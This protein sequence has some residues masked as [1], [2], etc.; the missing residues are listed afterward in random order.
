MSFF[1]NLFSRAIRVTIP[2]VILLTASATVLADGHPLLDRFDTVNLVASTVPANGDINP[3]GV[4]VIPHSDGLLVRGNILVSNFNNAANQQGTGTTIVQVSPG[5]S[6]TLF[7][8]IDASSLGSRCPGGVGLTTALVVLKRGWVI[9]GSLPTTD[10]TSAT[11]SAG[12]LI[13]LD[14]A[15]QVVE[16]FMGGG[17]NGPW[18]MTALD[19]EDQAL[20][21]VTNV[22]NGDVTQGA[23]HIVN[24]GTVLRLALAV[25][26]SGTGS[27]TLVSTT[28]IG[29]GFAETADPNSLVIGPTGV[30]L[31][32]D[33]TLYVA[34]SVN[35]RIAAI[36]N[37]VARTTTANTGIDVS[38]GGAL[39]DPLGLLVAPNGDVVTANGGDGNLVET[40]PQG[41][42]VAVVTVETATGAGSLFGIALGNGE[43]GL[44]FVD[45]GDNTLK[46]FTREKK[47]R[48]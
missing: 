19:N 29:S 39:M 25:P 20:L 11:A 13:V 26:K 2:A 27:P 12:C 9:V 16:T 24:Q 35:S 18:D 34:D 30:G 23:P 33:G 3:Y 41:A 21:F 45:D 22:L 1:H 4:A 31:G 14:S 37:A 40:T 17:I 44:Y 6:V 5:G 15:G 7:A 46:V 8:Q 10:G 28:E 36:Q 48:H 32:S 38:V 42:Q 47:S 43:R